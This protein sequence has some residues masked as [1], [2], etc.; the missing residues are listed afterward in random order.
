[1]A[2]MN[3]KRTVYC[4][5]CYEKGHNRRGCPKLA[6]EIKAK[7][8]ATGEYGRRCSWCK[9]KGHT[10]PKCLARA[11]EIAKYIKE[12]AAY[13]QEVLSM[14]EQQGLGIGA[15][16]H[17]EVSDASKIENENL[18]IVKDIDWSAVQ[19]KNKSNRPI[20]VY[21][22]VR[23]WHMEYC[24]PFARATHGYTWSYG[25]VQVV[26]KAKRSIREDMPADWLDGR[27]GIEKVYR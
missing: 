8:S 18:G 16:V 22:F 13:R 17:P 24:V 23:D 15:L 7:Y 20:Q 5:H 11:D 4:R 12:N 3:G 6:P 26:T 21:N 14:M 25:Q 9:Q 19:V 1:M 2:Y 27:S 10:K